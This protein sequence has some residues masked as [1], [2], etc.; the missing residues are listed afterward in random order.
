MTAKINQIEISPAE[1]LSQAREF[2][3][4]NTETEFLFVQKSGESDT[5]GKLEISKE[6]QVEL[7]DIV[8]RCLA[9]YVNDLRNGSVRPRRLDVANTV[10]DESVVQCAPKGNLPDTRLFSALVSGECDKTGSYPTDSTPNIQL[11]RI[12]EPDGK[13][14]VGVQSHHDVKL[15]QPNS[16]LGARMFYSNDEY[17]KFDGQVVTVKPELRAVYYDD[18]LFIDDASVFESIFNME[19]AYREKAEEAMDALEDSGIIITDGTSDWLLSHINI[20]RAMYEIYDED[21][22]EKAS[23]DEIEETIEE[24]DLNERFSLSYDRKNGKI[25]INV[26]KYQHT[27]KLIKA[28]SGKYADNAIRDIRWEIDS[29]RRM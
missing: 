16:S 19:D 20:L 7:S 11:I 28:L 2:A 21:I 4:G 1:K 3:N 22:H 8:A 17:Q 10:S 18:W 29:G 25:R 12:T 15:M 13:T 6:L 9:G 5:V 23:P 27:W 24:Y 14:L 26:G